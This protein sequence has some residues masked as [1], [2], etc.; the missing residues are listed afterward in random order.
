MEENV[1]P[2]L[3]DIGFL[4]AYRVVLE[5]DRIAHVVEKLFGTLFHG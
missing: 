1:T 5:P 3:G 4:R 2:N